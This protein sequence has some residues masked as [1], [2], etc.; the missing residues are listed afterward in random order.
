MGLSK[1]IL[2]YLDDHNILIAEMGA[3]HKGDIKILAKM[4]EPDYGIITTI[5]PQHL[6][7][8][9]SLETIED[10]KFELAENLKQDGVMIFNGDSNSTKKLYDRFD[11]KKYL[12]CDKNGF[13]YAEDIEINS[14]GSKFKLYI[15]GKQFDIETELLGKCNIDNIVTASTVAYLLEVPREDIENAVKELQPTKH[16]LEIIKNNACTVIDDSYNSNIIG[17]K[18]ALDTLNMFKGK[19]IVITPGMVELGNEQSEINFKFGGMIADVADYIIIMNN[20]NKNEILSG[21][22]AHNFKKE[23]IF[24]SNNCDNSFVATWFIYSLEVANKLSKG[25]TVVCKSF[26]YLL[27]IKPLSS[28]LYSFLN[29]ILPLFIYDSIVSLEN[30]QN[31]PS[32]G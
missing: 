29:F 31:L 24:S 30:A 10:T 11:G 16:R 21:A 13:S 1:T 26:L 18:E 15:D 4:V 6:E 9:K 27:N 14:R 32:G 28:S 17:C 22:I 23:N 2:E 8:F 25:I 5:G 20:V 7:T 3:R 19:K 12:V